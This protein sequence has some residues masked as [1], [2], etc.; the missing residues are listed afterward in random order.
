MSELLV[1]KREWLGQKENMACEV[2]L[3]AS[4]RYGGRKIT[5]EEIQKAVACISP[6]DSRLLRICASVDS[7]MESIRMQ[8][9][10]GS[11]ADDQEAWIR[12]LIY[13]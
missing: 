8:P 9:V 6:G 2:D 12:D 3:E 4:G 5:V 11:E 7:L 1:F 13:N 10:T